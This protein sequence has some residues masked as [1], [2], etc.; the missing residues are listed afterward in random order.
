MDDSWPKHPISCTNESFLQPP[1]RHMSR[2]TWA[3]YGDYGSALYNRR[4]RLK[5]S[6]QRVKTGT[7]LLREE[8]L[9]ENYE[10]RWKKSDI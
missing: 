3:M 6:F 1:R 7:N 8:T 4:R 9:T 2:D 10:E 5:V